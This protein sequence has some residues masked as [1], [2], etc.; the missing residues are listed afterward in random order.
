MLFTAE[1]ELSAD[2]VP[3][4]LELLSA[5]AETAVQSIKDNNTHS[6]I[7][8]IAFPFRISINIE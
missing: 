1:A 5:Q 6:I 8:F 7:R 4:A 3:S 2:D